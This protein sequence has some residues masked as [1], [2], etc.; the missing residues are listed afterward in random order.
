M[1]DVLLI[2]AM[3]KLGFAALSVGLLVGTL[4]LLDW[5]LGISFGSLM[6]EMLE[7]K[8]IAVAIYFGARILAV[9]LL[10]GAALG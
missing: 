2:S 1:N 4:R 10:I 6:D 7:A 5:T 3:F 8:G 9:A